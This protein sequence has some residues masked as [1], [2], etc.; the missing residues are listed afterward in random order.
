MKLAMETAACPIEFE[1][2]K[3]VLEQKVGC[4]VVL[5]IHTY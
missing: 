5:G 2:L 3:F 1:D 4:E